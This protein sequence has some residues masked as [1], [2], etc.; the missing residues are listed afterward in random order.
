[1]KGRRVDTSTLEPL[2]VPGGE[3]RPPV[4]QVKHLGIILD[5]RLKFNEHVKEVERR[6]IRDFH[7][8]WRL[9]GCFKELSVQG[10]QQLYIGCIQPI[11]EYGS[12]GWFPHS[13]K[14]QIDIV[15]K[16]QNI[17]LRVEP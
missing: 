4:D 2:M 6:A 14:K 7:Q 11:L 8:I 5:K 9:G 16:I 13:T 1:M 17:A 15:Q 12:E 10:F 3:P